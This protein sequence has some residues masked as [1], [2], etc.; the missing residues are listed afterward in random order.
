MDPPGDIEQCGT[1]EVPVMMGG[2]RSH[3][4][5]CPFVCRGLA[6]M[7]WDS[8]VVT[9][10]GLPLAKSGEI[11]VSGG[12]CDDEDGAFRLNGVLTGLS[13]VARRLLHNLGEPV[14]VTS[15]APSEL[16]V[17]RAQ[18]GRTL[19]PCSSQR[20]ATS[21]SRSRLKRAE[22]NSQW[23]L[24]TREDI[25][26]RSRTRSAKC[27]RISHRDGLVSGG[28]VITAEA[29]PLATCSRVFVDGFEWRDIRPATRIILNPDDWSG[30]KSI[31]HTKHRTF[32]GFDRGC[33]RSWRGDRRALRR[34]SSHASAI[35]RWR[36][37]G[38]LLCW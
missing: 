17:T 20:G 26:R 16:V 31:S 27:C 1:P 38:E 8:R 15:R 29:A 19:D 5:P 25:D 30:L 21:C 7:G 33:G 14:N 28:G 9:E 23:P 3:F 36:L 6:C 22:A 32:K 4:S 2:A 13:A 37:P 10:N 12:D 24:L 11:P 35:Y 34:R 18:Q